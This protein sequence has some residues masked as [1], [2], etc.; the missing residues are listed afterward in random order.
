MFFNFFNEP[1][2]I[3]AIFMHDVMSLAEIVCGH[4]FELIQILIK[5]Y[6]YKVHDMCFEMIYLTEVVNW[7]F[8]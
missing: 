6:D 2:S 5:C 8:K 3:S 4:I 7:F 1:G